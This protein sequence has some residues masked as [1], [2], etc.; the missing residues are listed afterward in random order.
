MHL[1]LVVIIITAILGFLA[2]LGHL[3]I[4]PRLLCW[5]ATSDEASLPLAGD[6]LIPDPIL[7]T[8]R[9]ITIK[10]DSTKVWPWLAQMGQGRGG[11]YS[12]DWLENLV[13]LNIHNANRIV[14]ELQS[15]KVGDLIPFWRGAGVKVINVEPPC[16][17]VLGG[18][19]YSDNDANQ[20]AAT[21]N[22]MGGTWVFALQEINPNVT[23]LLVRT[24]VAK[25]PPLWLSYFLVRILIEPAHFIMERGMLIGI[26]KRA[27][28]G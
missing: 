27:E 13:G 6:E 11:F 12:Y 9:A 18:T 14:L 4:R 1:T 16:V 7:L 20:R 10:V 22:H 23:R 28:A 19:L 2:T 24:K 26:R 8:T 17:L 15:I 25:F 3:F 21:D 5:G